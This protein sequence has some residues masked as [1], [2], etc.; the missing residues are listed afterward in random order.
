MFDDFVAYYNENVI[1][2]YIAY[3]D[4]SQDGV[5]GRSRDI[6]LALIAATSLFHLREHLPAPHAIT[7]ADLEKQCFDY[8][9]LGDLVN[10]T[11][12]GFLTNKTPHGSPLVVRASDIRERVVFVEYNDK[13]GAYRFP[14]KQVVAVL[15]DGSQRELLSLLTSVLN[16]WEE[17]L[18]GVGLL[19]LPRAFA[20]DGGIRFRTRE[21]SQRAR[22]DFEIVQGRRFSPLM[23]LMRWNPTTSSA[24]PIDLKGGNALFRIY[25]PKFDFEVTLAHEAS[26]RE[27]KAT[28]ELTDEE[29]Q[30]LA[31]LETE[32]EKNAYAMGIPAAQR[33]L[34]QLAQE[35]RKGAPADG[36]QLE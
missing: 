21:E 27:Y 9:L 6:R 3:R 28:V 11:K 25:R 36:K 34:A 16:F 5:S 18:A 8:S 1:D 30:V 15:T 33:A 31:N 14:H 12:H 29:C 35:A 19:K 22:L 7:R 26:A 23:Q 2:P 24:E 17:W 10:V 32:E 4:A 20:H 13:D